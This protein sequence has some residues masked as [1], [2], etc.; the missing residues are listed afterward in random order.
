MIHVIATIEAHP[1]RRGDLLAEF[2]R[3]VPLVRAEEGCFEYGPAVDAETDL[4][5]Q[6]RTGADVVTVIEKW[7]SIAHLKRHL[8]T[9]HMQEYRVRVQD[10]V[11]RIEIAVLTPA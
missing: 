7:A 1:G 10:V 2:A 5:A 6:H 4:E 8:D 3:I 9:P 11:A